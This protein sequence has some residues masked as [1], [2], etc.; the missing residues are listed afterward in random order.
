MR[1]FACVLV[2]L[3]LAACQNTS[4]SRQLDFKLDGGATQTFDFTKRG[5]LPADNGVYKVEGLGLMLY[6]HPQSKQVYFAWDVV[7]NVKAQAVNKI[8]V[9]Q[10]L[11]TGGLQALLVDARPQHENGEKWRQLSNGGKVNVQASRWH[12]VSRG[13]PV[14]SAAWL[15]DTQQDSMFVF[16]IEI[17]DSEH[18]IHVLY[19]PMVISADSKVE[20]AKVIAATK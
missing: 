11:N 2:L 9:S 1:N 20:Y 5:A 18:K 4:P 10:V 6:Q 7:V 3:L 8:S 15:N 14:S 12:A 19:Q 13:R 17:E 16:K